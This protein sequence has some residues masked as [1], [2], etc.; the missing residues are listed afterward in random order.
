MSV[1]AA[2]AVCG[3]AL[4]LFGACTIT[5]TAEELALARDIWGYFRPAKRPPAAFASIAELHLSGR[6]EYGWKASPPNYGML[7]TTGRRG[8]TYALMQPEID[9]LNIRFATETVRGVSYEFAGSLSRADFSRGG[10]PLDEVMLRGTMRKL[11]DGRQ[12]AAAELSFAFEEG[13]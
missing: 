9:G 6:G 3:A 2:K 4:I 11:Q 7:K 13:G 10:I 5:G 8:A 12:M 1:R